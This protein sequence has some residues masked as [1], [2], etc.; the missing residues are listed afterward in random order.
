MQKNKGQW[1]CNVLAGIIFVA[2][3]AIHFLWQG[4][5]PEQ[6]PLQ[7]Q[8]LSLP[9]ENS[10]FRSYIEADSYWL[11]YSYALSAAFAAAAFYNYLKSPCRSSRTF[12]IGGISLSGF[13]AVAGCFLIG[14]CGSPMFVVWLNIFGATFIPFAK[15]FIALVTTITIAV[16]WWWMLQRKTRPQD[17][18]GL[19]KLSKPIIEE[20]SYEY[21][22]RKNHSH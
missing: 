10:W 13:L 15:P 20:K 8:W 17:E 5:F 6:D 7:S 12:V 9:T 2:V 18:I 21:S 4:V 14:C 19:S 11:G 16:A 22:G 3:F 1:F